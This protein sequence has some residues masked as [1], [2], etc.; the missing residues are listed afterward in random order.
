MVTADAGKTHANTAYTRGAA[1]FV[2][3]VPTLLCLVVVVVLLIRAETSGVHHEYVAIVCWAAASGVFTAVAVRFTRLAIV[4]SPQRLT[5]RNFWTTRHIAWKEIEEIAPPP[6]LKRRSTAVHGQTGPGL[7][8]TLTGGRV[9]IANA[10][11]RSRGDRAD[12]ADPLV[13]E[14]RQAADAFRDTPSAS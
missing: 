11:A 12:F 3:V 2:G 13:H 9:I 10:Y 4:A 5:V 6:A 7:R 1:F 8:I 14:L